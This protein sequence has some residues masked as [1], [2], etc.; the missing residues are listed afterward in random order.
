MKT[1]KGPKRW[2][3]P[4]PLST[5]RTKEGTPRSRRGNEAEWGLIEKSASLPRRLQFQSSP[6]F[7]GSSLFSVQWDDDCG[8]SSVRS[9]MFIAI[10][11]AETRTR[12]LRSGMKRLLDFHFRANPWIRTSRMP[13]LTEL[14]PALEFHSKQ[15]VTLPTE[16]KS[17]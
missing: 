12:S 8:K 1:A 15:R 10:S 9:A 6:S 5:K 16:L 13:L 2:G 14:A 11:H 4:I 7:D 3:R 17:L